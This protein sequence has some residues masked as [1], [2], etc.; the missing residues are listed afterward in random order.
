MA[1]GLNGGGGEWKHEN[2]YA[3][4]GHFYHPKCV[5]KML[6]EEGDAATQELQEEIA[7]GEPFTCHAHKCH[8]CKKGEHEKVEALQFAGNAR[9]HLSFISEAVKRDK[10]LQKSE[11]FAS[12][13]E[14]KPRK[15]KAL[16]ENTEV[17]MK[18][19]FIVDDMNDECGDEELT[20]KQSKSAICAICDDGGDLTCCE[21]KC[22]EAF[23]ATIEST[24]SRCESLGLRAEIAEITTGFFDVVLQPVAFFITQ[25]VL[26]RCFMRKVMLQHRNFKK[27]IAA[28]EPF[29][30]HAHKCHKCKKGEHEKVEALQFAGDARDAELGTPLRNLKFP[31]IGHSKK[32]AVESL[33]SKK[34][35]AD[36]DYTS[37]KGYFSK[38]QK[39]RVGKFS[40]S[41]RPV[42]S[43][44]KRV[45]MS[46]GSES[47]KRQRVTEDRENW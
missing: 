29:A 33:I 4:C 47:M 39:T 16:D 21:G 18:P 27:K 1:S 7:A 19:S 14:K 17:T 26:Q 43:S 40:S 2:R 9:D 3:T 22:L 45:K 32:Q 20:L 6:H 24:E 13:L 5:A 41:I 37:E 42:D 8:K 38:S 10:T 46:S 31:D 34:E 28:G 30:C 11:F 23:H 12:F 15:R 35:V 25:S 44:K 36:S